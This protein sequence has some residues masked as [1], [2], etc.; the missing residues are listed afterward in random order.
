[1][2]GAVD[3]GLHYIRRYVYERE[4]GADPDTAV[5]RTH[6]TVGRALVFANIAIL[7][8]FSV[9]CLSNFVPTI[10]FGILVGVAMLG[11]LAGNLFL[12][13]LLLRLWSA[14]EAPP[15]PAPPGDD[16]PQGDSVN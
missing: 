10:H 2:G 11:G 13:P 8:G 14:R 16:P 1:M 7:I 9:L 5:R 6:A 12:L 3:R 15:T 4:H